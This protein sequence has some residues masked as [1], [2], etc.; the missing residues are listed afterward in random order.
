MVMF[1]IAGLLLAAAAA[2]G[3]ALDARAQEPT[4]LSFGV[5]SYKKPTDV[6]LSF[7]PAVQ[8]LQ[9]A[10]ST[11]LGRPVRIDV[12]V[13][14]TYEECL[15]AFVAGE[16]DLVRF[17]PA[18]YV[19]AQQ[20][21]PRIQLLVAEQEDGRK[22]CKGVIA[23]RADSDIRTL[24][25]LKGKRFAFGNEQSTIGRYLSQAEL[26]K[27]GIHAAD[28]ASYRYLDRHDNVYK[29]VEIGD[30]DA[31]AL[32]I[33]TFTDLNH[34]GGKLRVLHVF[35]NVGKPWIARAGLP[36]DLTR[37]MR[38]CLLELQDPKALAALQVCGLLPAT[39]RDYQPVRDGM[40]LSD[41]FLAVPTPPAPGRQP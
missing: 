10:A 12:R 16:V 36:E 3:S 11:R 40:R 26:V 30:H 17:G 25:D 39:D 14:K 8:H 32:H 29:S 19:L 9:A 33:D 23:V 24:A 21:N 5:Y 6:Y 18:S 28:L 31:G 22:T 38:R 2:C 4:T 27:A 41:R 15:E 34:E 7:Q 37:C 1:R 35:D 13:F 20:R